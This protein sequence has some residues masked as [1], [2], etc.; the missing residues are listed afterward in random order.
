AS[1]TWQPFTVDP[2]G[3]ALTAV[4]CA[5]PGRCIAV[6]DGGGAYTYDGGSWSAAFPVD[7]GQAFT[8]VSCPSRGFCAATD[9]G[10]NGAILAGGL[11][12]PAAGFC[13]ATTASGGAVAYRNGAWSPV[14]RIDGRRVVGVVSCPAPAAC[15][16]VDRRDNVLYYAPPSS[17]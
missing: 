7:A 1:N 4:S 6:D 3:G 5:G 15:T 17:G 16:A 10:G 11:A 2:S 13:M 12:C 8:A 9:A 14:T